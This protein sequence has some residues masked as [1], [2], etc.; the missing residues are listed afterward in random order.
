MYT[1][2]ESGNSPMNCQPDTLKTIVSVW[3]A[4]T[5]HKQAGDEG[6][7]NTRLET[8]CIGHTLAEFSSPVISASGKRIASLQTSLTTTQGTELVKEKKVLV[9]LLWSST[10]TSLH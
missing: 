5:Q 2:A 8:W 6:F 7:E 4:K 9:Y 10:H 3:K 1:R